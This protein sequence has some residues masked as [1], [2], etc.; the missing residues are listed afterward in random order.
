MHFSFIA[1]LST[2]RSSSLSGLSS[3]VIKSPSE[4]YL[5]DFEFN[6]IGGLNGISETKSTII[7]GTIKSFSSKESWLYNACKNCN[8]K[9]STKTI[10]NDKQD[11]S[12]GFDEVVVL[13]CN[14]DACNTKV[15]SS[16]PR[17]GVP[18]RVQDCTVI[19]TLTLFEHAVVKL[20]KVSP[21]QLLDKNIELANEGSFP[22]ERKASLNRKFAFKIA[23]GSFNIKNKSDGYSV[24]KLTENPLV[25]SVLDKKFDD[26]HSSLLMRS[27]LIFMVIF[28][29]QLSA[30]RSSSLS[31][32]SSSV[33]KSP[34]EEYLTDFEFSTIGGLNGISETKSTIILGTIKSFASK[35]SWL[36]N[37]CKNCN[38]KVSTKTI[39]NDKQNGS[40]GFDE[41]M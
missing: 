21:N 16:F 12:E 29:A 9:V 30:E 24:S 2:E 33:I 4:E 3:S 17:I 38:R 27:L 7:L 14:T 23:V 36:Y 35:E 39:L 31:G 28:I 19:V 26:I 22:G 20:L 37:A 41:T 34:S 25:I 10:L 18:I 13:E 1:Q 11:G 6:T 5:T 40:E 15:S 8:R 32:L